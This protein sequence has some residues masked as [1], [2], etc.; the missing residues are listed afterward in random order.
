MNSNSMYEW[1]YSQ[2]QIKKNLYKADIYK[3]NSQKTVFFSVNQMKI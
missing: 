1:I 3:A 2:T